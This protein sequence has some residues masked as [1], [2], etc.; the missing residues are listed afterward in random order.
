MN[1]TMDTAS[2][3]Y[4]AYGGFHDSPVPDFSVVFST[5]E[6][7]VE[8]LTRTFRFEEATRQTLLK[9][10]YAKLNP[11]LFKVEYCVV[12]GCSCGEPSAHSSDR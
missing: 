5:R 8:H 1:Q 4:I 2:K 6:E 7:A 9:R 12:K 11:K 10:G 3:H